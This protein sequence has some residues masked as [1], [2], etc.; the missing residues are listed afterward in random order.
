MSAAQEKKK[1]KK[2]KTHFKLGLPICHK[3]WDIEFFLLALQKYTFLES[4]K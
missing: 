1:S 3:L 4:W 2:K